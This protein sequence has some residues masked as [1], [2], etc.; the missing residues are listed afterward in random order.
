[1]P[2]HH[3]VILYILFGYTLNLANIYW[4]SSIIFMLLKPSEAGLTSHKPSLACLL[5]YKV[6]SVDSPQHMMLQGDLCERESGFDCQMCCLSLNL[7]GHLYLP[8]SRFASPLFWII[9]SHLHDPLWSYIWQTPEVL[10]PLGN[11]FFFFLTTK[12]MLVAVPCALKWLIKTSLN[13]LVFSEW[14]HM[15]SSNSWAPRTC[16][17]DI[18]VWSL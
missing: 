4:L 7:S 16:Q 13:L 6:P 14:W 1:M 17:A 3:I 8:H 2:W 18:T 5:P 10:C 15:F 11:F 12:Q 9:P